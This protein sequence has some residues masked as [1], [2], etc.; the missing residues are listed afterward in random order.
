MLPD[1]SRTF[2]FSGSR[3]V[4]SRCRWQMDFLSV[5]FLQIV[6]NASPFQSDFDK[7][8][9]LYGGSG[10][11]AIIPI[12]PSGSRLRIPPTAA[13][14][15][16]PPPMIKY[17]KS[18]LLFSFFYSVSTTS[19][20]FRPPKALGVD[21]TA[22]GSLIHFPSTMYW[23][24]YCPGGKDSSLIHRPSPMSRIHVFSGLQSLNVPATQTLPAFSQ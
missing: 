11:S 23:Y 24:S 15:V 12:L 5:G 7:G 18:F 17:L 19:A 3:K 1:A 6:S 20:E 14:P 4:A 2:F 21:F 13:S 9:R 22:R 8:G 16:I 10:S